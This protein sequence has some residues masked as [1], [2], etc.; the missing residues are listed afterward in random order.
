MKCRTEP[1][2][3]KSAGNFCEYFEFIRSIWTP[4]SE[5]KGRQASARD[6]LKKLFGD[7]GGSSR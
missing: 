7:Q 3:E 4:K 5:I 6:T 1:V 2:L